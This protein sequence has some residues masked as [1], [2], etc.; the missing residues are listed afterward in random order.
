MTQPIPKTIAVFRT[1]RIGEVLLST[2]AVDIL[3]K[4]YPASSIIFFT[5]KYS[6][7]LLHNRKDINEVIPLDIFQRRHWVG[8]ALRLARM[9]KSRR[10]GMSIV[11]NPSKTVHLAC[12][13]ARVRRRCGFDRKWGSLLTDRVNDCRN[14]GKQHEVEYTKEFFRALGIPAADEV[15][16]SLVVANKMKELVR[17]RLQERGVDLRKQLVIVHPCAS[18]PL[19][20]WPRQKYIELS[21][22]LGSLSV[23]LVLIGEQKEYDELADM[24]CECGCHV[25]N[26]AGLFDL[27]ELAA[28]INIS[29]LFIGNDSGPMHMAAALGVPVI[30]IF[31]K[32]A[33][34]SNP[35]RWRPWGEGHA[36]F[37]ELYGEKPCQLKHFSGYYIAKDEIEPSDVLKL[38]CV[39]LNE[40]L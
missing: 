1:D 3:R 32:K 20:C 6:A 38:S 26:G 13:F 17:L 12:F 10:C 35:L 4:A 31:S 11:L 22:Q 29:D 15:R 28:V 19:K 27:E 16:P 36:I 18:N 30:A 9:L 33:T 40:R 21:R 37:H 23:Q 14:D 7:A 24:V 5:S 2:V 39:Y 8:D 34:G 25:L